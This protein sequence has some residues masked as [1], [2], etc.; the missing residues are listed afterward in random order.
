MRFI[1]KGKDVTESINNYYFDNRMSLVFIIYN[2]NNKRYSY[3]YKDV[4]ILPHSFKEIEANQ[5]LIYRTSNKV[6]A[7]R[8]ISRYEEIGDGEN[9]T[10]KINKQSKVMY[11]KKRNIAIESFENYIV[12]NDE[13]ILFDGEIKNVETIEFSDSLVRVKFPNNEEKYIMNKNYIKIIKNIKAHHKD[14]FDYYK[15]IAVLKI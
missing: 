6:E 10:I 3:Q 12:K 2:G 4:E 15:Y 13:I 14:L 11:Y 9:S 1:I 7:L 8:D 5:I